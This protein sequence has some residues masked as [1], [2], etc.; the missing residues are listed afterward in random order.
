MRNI[1]KRRKKFKILSKKFRKNQRMA[2]DIIIDNPTITDPII[3][4]KAMFWSTS[5]SLRTENGEIFV[6]MKKAIT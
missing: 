2:A 1:E 6:I 3:I 4:H 5:I